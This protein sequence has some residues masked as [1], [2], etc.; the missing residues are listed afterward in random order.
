[1]AMFEDHGRRRREAG[2]RFSPAPPRPPSHAPLPRDIHL[3]KPVS[4][5]TSASGFLGRGNVGTRGL[6]TL[7]LQRL[8]DKRR[9]A[10]QRVRMCVA[11]L[12][13]IHWRCVPDANGGIFRRRLGKE[14][15]C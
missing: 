11:F 1:M 12:H 7:F 9:P 15:E 8:V 2:K 3:P 14:T 5:R 4:T 10:R 13:C 6:N